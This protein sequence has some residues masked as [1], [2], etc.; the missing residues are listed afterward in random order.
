MVKSKSQQLDDTFF[1]LSDPTRRAIL[2]QLAQGDGKV[3]ELSK[4]FDV[5]APA[6]SKHLRI[7]ERAGLLSQQRQGRGRLCHLEPKPLKEAASFVNTYRRFW[8]SKLDILADYLD[9]P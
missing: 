4:P 6:I 9:G 8:R 5:S 7:L 3:G 1:A 2:A